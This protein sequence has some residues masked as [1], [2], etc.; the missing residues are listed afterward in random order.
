MDVVT[1]WVNGSNLIINGDVIWG[2]LMVALPFCPMT[3]I[4]L[5]LA[6]ETFNWHSKPC[7]GLFV[8]IFVL[9]AAVLATP[10]YMGIVLFGAILRL[11]A[12]LYEDAE[13]VMRGPIAGCW[14]DLKDMP[15]QFRMVEMVGE[16]YPQ[17]L[18]GELVPFNMVDST[19]S[20]HHCSQ[21]HPKF[22]PNNL[23]NT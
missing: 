5:Q 11:W 22:S 23:E 18:L 7:G 8:L 16:S 19:S 13:D 1:D 10:L 12:P 2:G 17:A 15:I 20:Y 3:I 9:P 6:L 21:G 14:Q 4:M